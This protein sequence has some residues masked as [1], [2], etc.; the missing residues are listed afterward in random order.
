MNSYHSNRKSHWLSLGITALML[1]PSVAQNYFT[2]PYGPGGT[3][4]LYEVVNTAVQYS[5]AK[6]AAEA[7]TADQT[8]LVP[9]TKG[10]H[11]IAIS[12]RD[13]NSFAIAAASVVTGSPNVWL[14]LTDDPAFG[15][16]ESG[17]HNV[18]DP[19]LN[20]GAGWVWLGEAGASTALQATDFV[21]WAP[22]E[23]NNSAGTPIE[24][25]AE[26]RADG[27]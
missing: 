25:I 18:N 8:I 5:T 4:N 21:A 15:G 6:S 12:S 27:L 7:K 23:P 26:L 3:W 22:G 9:D 17:A 24:N 1:S 20:R 16:F 2:G 19:S 11:L 13:E 14:G 10:G